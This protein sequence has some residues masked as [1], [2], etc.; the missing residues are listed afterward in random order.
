M[1]FMRALFAAAM[2]AVVLAVGQAGFASAQTPGTIE[3]HARVCPTD[4]AGNLFDECHDNAPDQAYSYSLDG[5]VAEPVDAEG[6]VSFTGL[7]AGTYE[8][9]QEEGIPLDFAHLRVFCSVQDADP[10]AFEVTVDVNTFSVDLGDGEHVVCDVY[11]IPE[12]LSGLTPTPETTVAPT[13]TPGVTLP[14]TGSGIESSSGMMAPIA[15]ALVAVIAGGL[16]L[17]AIRRPARE[18]RA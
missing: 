2:I 10:E 8:V 1:R 12:N 16:A 11:T 9:S 14:N 17:M 4:T 5:G 3:I 6:N 13:S 15:F 18:T 7:A